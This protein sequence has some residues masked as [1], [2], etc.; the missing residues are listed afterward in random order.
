MISFHKTF[1]SLRRPL[2]RLPLFGIVL[3]GLLLGGCAGSS[4][5]ASRLDAQAVKPLDEVAVVSVRTEKV[6][7]SEIGEKSLDDTEN[8]RKAVGKITEVTERQ[9]R[10]ANPNFQAASMQV[11]DYLFGTF[12]SAAPFSLLSESSVLSSSAYQTVAEKQN[13]HWRS[14]LFASPQ[15]YHSLS[16]KRLKSASVQRLL[17]QLPADSDGILLAKTTYTLVRDAVKKARGTM[18]SS[19]RQNGTNVRTTLAEGDTV[20]VDVKATIRIRVLDRNGHT[21]MNVVQTAR[22]DEGFTFVYGEGWNAEQINGAARQATQAATGNITN[23]LRKKLPENVIA[24]N[25]SVLN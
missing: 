22:S 12:R 20:S 24:E 23:Q 19:V 13:D 17:E 7:Q 6:Y 5:V 3:A 18:W 10:R 21:A 25:S 11:R 14:S 4:N 15:G 8:V 2:Q 9:K 16:P 1:S